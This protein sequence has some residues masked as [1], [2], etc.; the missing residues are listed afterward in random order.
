MPAAAV[1][2]APLSY[3]YVLLLFKTLSR[4]EE[5]I[6]RLQRAHGLSELISRL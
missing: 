5:K 4:A 2:P 6:L 3:I 1:N